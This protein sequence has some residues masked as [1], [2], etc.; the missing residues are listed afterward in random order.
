[1]TSPAGEEPREPRR[2][3]PSDRVQPNNREPELL[4][5]LREFEDEE[6]A[7]RLQ[8]IVEEEIVGDLQWQGFDTTTPE[9]REFASALAE[10]GYSV[11]MGWLV[12]GTVYRM[13]AQH[14]GG[15]G[16]FGLEKIPEGLRLF[17]DEA[18]AVAAELMIRSIKA[19]RSKTLM[20]PKPEKRWRA[21]GGSSIKSFFVG[22]CLMEFPDVYQQW[23]RQEQRFGVEGARYAALEKEERGGD[24]VDPEWAGVASTELQAMRDENDA[25]TMVMF[26]LQVAGYTYAE[27]ADML[28]TVGKP[29]TTAQVRTR[30]SRVRSAAR[31]TRT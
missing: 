23:A 12:S 1:M 20:N 26:E 10:Y 8:R 31:S 27:I 5:E 14:A 13:A 24:Q 4:G 21:D 6:S 29:T 18:R 25:A 15:R 30:I 28:S 9:W 2:L 19:F 16:V 17:G 7:R 11:F 3:R 22:R